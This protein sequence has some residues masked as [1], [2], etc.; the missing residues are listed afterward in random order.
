[1]K[2]IKRLESLKNNVNKYMTDLRPDRLND[3]PV[4]TEAGHKSTTWCTHKWKNVFRCTLLSVCNLLFSSEDSHDWMI[5][6]SGFDS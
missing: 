1:M 5:K 6:V 4:R 2:M 3:L